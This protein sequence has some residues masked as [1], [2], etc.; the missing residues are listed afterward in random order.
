MEKLKYKTELVYLPYIKRRLHIATPP[1]LNNSKYAKRK[2]FTASDFSSKLQKSIEDGKPML[3]GRFG[4]TEQRILIQSTEKKLGIR[5]QIDEKA[6]N[7]LCNNSGFF[8]FPTDADADR[9][10]ELYFSSLKELDFLG[11]WY[12]F[13]E[14]Y[15][16][17]KYC[18]KELITTNLG[19][20]EPWN[21]KENPWSKVLKGKKVLFIHPF[22]DTITEQI[23][24]RDKLF[25]NTEILPEFDTYVLK[26]VQTL[27]GNSDSRFQNWFEAF[28]YMYEE[29][30]KIPFD[31]AIIGCGAYGLP[32]AAKI[33]KAGKQAIHLGGAT[34]LFWGI[35]GNRWDARP[36][37]QPLFNEYWT[38][39]LPS[40]MMTNSEKV[41]DSCYW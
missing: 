34:Q 29:A 6:K 1:H 12:N 24:K 40:D 7:A 15:L 26:A 33:K 41:E 13:G 37:F 30:M 10:S 5:S 4:S 35:R 3:L 27:A 2:F 39:P 31:I 36:D 17:K 23:K 14:D 25:P 38:H 16:I 32:L 28:D 20:L 19:S 11:C 22:K 18:K 9:F 8:P 21:C